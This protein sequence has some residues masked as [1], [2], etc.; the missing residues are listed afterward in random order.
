MNRVIRRCKLCTAAF[1]PT[2]AINGDCSKSVWKCL[3]RIVPSDPVVG[4]ACVEELRSGCTTGLFFRHIRACAQMKVRKPFLFSI[5]VCNV[6][7][8]YSSPAYCVRSVYCRAV[9]VEILDAVL[10]FSK[11]GGEQHMQ[12]CIRLIAG[13]KSSHRVALCRINRHWHSYEV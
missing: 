7:Q 3:K 1:I 4:Y 2:I 8:Q 9:L 6:W 13:Y 11:L 10:N 12:H 5:E